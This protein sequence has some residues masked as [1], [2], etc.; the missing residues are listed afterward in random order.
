MK[1]FAKGGILHHFFQ[2]FSLMKQAIAPL[3]LDPLGHAT[4]PVKTSNPLKLKI[5]LFSMTYGED[6][7]Y[8]NVFQPCKFTPRATT[9]RSFQIY[10]LVMSRFMKRFELICI[11]ENIRI[12]FYFHK[13][14]IFCSRHKNR[15]KLS[16]AH[17]MA[18][19]SAFGICDV[20]TPLR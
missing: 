19:L 9:C 3:P 13:T 14:L 18:Y 11:V 12:Y 2:Y 16:Y 1:N 17:K 20:K 15:L 8:S 5:F 6:Q 4:H 7:Q 10:T